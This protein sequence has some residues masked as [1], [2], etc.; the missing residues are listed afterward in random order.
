MMRDQATLGQRILFVLILL[1]VVGVLA[2][3]TRGMYDHLLM[4]DGRFVV[5]NCTDHPLDVTL[6]LPSGNQITFT[7]KAQASH[8]FTDTATG[9]G[10]IGVSIP[11]R[12]TESLGYVTSMNGIIILSIDDD[13]VTFTQ[14]FP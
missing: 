10:A 6:D 2:W 4:L 12:P 5:V 3:I 8:T 11:G 13:S 1:V 14:E 9:E 7:I